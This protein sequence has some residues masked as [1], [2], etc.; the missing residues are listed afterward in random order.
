[1]KKDETYKQVVFSDKKIK[2]YEKTIK[3]ST[4]EKKR[5][6]NR[7]LDNMVDKVFNKKYQLFL[8]DI[9]IKKD[10]QELKKVSDEL[11][12]FERSIENKLEALK[13]AVKSQ[14]KKVETICQ[15]Q[16]KI[17]GWDV[18]FGSYDSEYDDYNSKLEKIC[19]EELTNQFRKSTKEG[20]ELDKLDDY[21]RNLL[22]TLSYPNLMA[23]AVDLNEALGNGSNMLNYAL[24]PNTLKQIEN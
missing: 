13:D 10:L 24:N 18:Y 1:M 2:T 22:L 3:E 20:Q 8:K 6:L 9:K 5:Q 11:T 17:N 23:R 19:R 14:A 7:A 16:A 12:N 4:A 21:A 15:R